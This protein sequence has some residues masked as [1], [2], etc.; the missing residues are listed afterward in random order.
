M[1]L[2]NELFTE[3]SYLKKLIDVAAS[4]WELQVEENI[5]VQDHEYIQDGFIVDK[6]TK[7]LVFRQ[8][9]FCNVMPN[10]DGITT[11]HLI[12]D[13]QED[14]IVCQAYK[15]QKPLV[16]YCF[17]SKRSQTADEFRNY[18]DL[19]VGGPIV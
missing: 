13:S 7:M 10:K 15:N 11:I 9:I 17:C 8:H 19:V 4:K 5:Y 1:D 2:I 6:S 3:T 16:N 14:T 18:I 12:H